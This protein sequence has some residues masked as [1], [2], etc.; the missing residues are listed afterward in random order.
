MAR[1]HIAGEGYELQVWKVPT[2]SRAPCSVVE[3]REAENLY[4]NNP[5]YTKMMHIASDLLLLN[6]NELLC[7]IKDG[8]F[9]D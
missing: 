6:G 3:G 7:T 4:K 5:V 8:E 1:P 2:K 9:L